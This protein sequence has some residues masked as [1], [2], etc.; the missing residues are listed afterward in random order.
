MER[1]ILSSNLDYPGLGVPMAERSKSLDF[2]TFESPD[3]L[4]RKNSEA[5]KSGIASENEIRMC[6][7]RRMMSLGSH[8]LSAATTRVLHSTFTRSQL[9]MVHVEKTD[10]WTRRSQQTPGGPHYNSRLLKLSTK[11]MIDRFTPSYSD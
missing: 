10:Y 2:G 9:A 5:P 11:T 8:P 4:C 6:V 7:I 3:L 1:I